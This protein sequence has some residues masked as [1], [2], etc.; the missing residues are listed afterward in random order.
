M[1]LLIASAERLK[2]L[3]A[4]LEAASG[5]KR[6]FGNTLDYILSWHGKKACP[7]SEVK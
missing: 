5:T 2:E 7:S 6:P 1:S 4:E 3:T